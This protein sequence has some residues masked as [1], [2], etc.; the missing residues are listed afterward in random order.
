[1]FDEAPR[2]FWRASTLTNFQF[3]IAGMVAALAYLQLRERRPKWLRG[4][5]AN[6]DLWLLAAVPLIVPFTFVDYGWDVLCPLVSFLIVGAAAFPHLERGRVTRVLWWRPLA[7]LGLASYSV[8]LWHIYVLDY[9]TGKGID[10]FVLLTL[11]A[12]P[13]SIA[14]AAISYKLIEEP[15]LRLR[16]RWS[17]SAPKQERAVML[18]PRK[19]MGGAWE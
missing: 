6:S 5:A 7:A 14:A 2:P 19:S 18:S 12:V 17:P 3:I 9:L 11:T 16:R 1:V 15:F 4:P 10:G 8:Y 13:I